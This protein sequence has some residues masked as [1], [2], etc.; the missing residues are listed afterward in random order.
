MGRESKGGSHWFQTGSRPVHHSYVIVLYLNETG[1]RR[2][3][4]EAQES[5][6]TIW[7]KGADTA[8]SIDLGISRLFLSNDTLL[9]NYGKH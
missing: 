2:S 4:Q 9:C 7:V 1:C 6:A 5:E 3:S 8:R